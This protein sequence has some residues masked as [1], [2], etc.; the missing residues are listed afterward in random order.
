[1]D[2]PIVIVSGPASP[3][4]FGDY[5]S[6]M[7]VGAHDCI[8]YPFQQSHFDVILESAIAAYSRGASTPAGQNEDDFVQSGAA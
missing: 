3:I 6:A 2:I 1:M 8:C 5:L 7:N 4:E